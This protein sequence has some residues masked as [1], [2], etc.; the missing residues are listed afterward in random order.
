MELASLDLSMLRTND[1][2]DDTLGPVLGTYRIGG[3]RDILLR[4]EDV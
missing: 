1:G 2:Y 4:R 3:V